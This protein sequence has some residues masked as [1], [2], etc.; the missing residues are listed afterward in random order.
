MLPGLLEI[1]ALAGTIQRDFPILT[2]TL[3]TD[4]AMHRGTK[5]LFFAFFADGA[6]QDQIL[7]QHYDMMESL[8]YVSGHWLCRTKH[9]SDQAFLTSALWITAIFMAFSG[10][11]TKKPHGIWLKT[12]LFNNHWV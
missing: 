6:T 7:G 11:R 5:P 2:A 1:N 10:P 3:W 4:A 12:L 8:F 9:A